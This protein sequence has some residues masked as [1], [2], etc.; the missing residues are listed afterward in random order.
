MCPRTRTGSRCRTRR[1]RGH[2]RRG[3]SVSLT[4]TLPGPDATRRRFEATGQPIQSAEAGQ[5][6]VVVIRD[7]TDRSLRQRQS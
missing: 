4:F 3:E 2:A 1:R 5:G 6:S 7:V